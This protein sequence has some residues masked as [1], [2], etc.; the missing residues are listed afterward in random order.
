V[1]IAGGVFREWIYKENWKE[2]TIEELAKIFKDKRMLKPTMI[3]Y[4]NWE[5]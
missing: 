3:A 4:K 1:L 2:K 5:E